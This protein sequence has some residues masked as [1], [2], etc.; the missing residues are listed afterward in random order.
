MSLQQSRVRV[1]VGA[2]ERL[3]TMRALLG[4]PLKKGN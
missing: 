2:L 4:F 1:K 3:G